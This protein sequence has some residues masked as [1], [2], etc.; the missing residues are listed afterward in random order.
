MNSL[1]LVPSVRSVFSQDGAVLMDIKQGM[2]YTSNPVGGRI[3][4]LLSQGMSAESVVEAISRECSV[5]Q[6]TVR[7]D[8][9]RFV[10][11]LRSYGLVEPEKVSA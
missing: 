5:S 11:Q 8:L 10:E 7:H 3:V 1:N 6:D 9:E 2:M 4:E